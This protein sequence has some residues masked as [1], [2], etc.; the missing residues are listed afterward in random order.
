M[1]TFQVSVHHRNEKPFGMGRTARE[2]HSRIVGGWRAEVIEGL[3]EGTAAYTGVCETRADA[4]KE[5]VSNLQ[6]RG[7]SGR[8]QV[9]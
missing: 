4:L 5:L 2:R 7:F 6:S 1:A 8:L 3:P 9:V